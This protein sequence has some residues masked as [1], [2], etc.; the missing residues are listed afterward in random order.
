MPLQIAALCH[1]HIIGPT[2]TQSS[3]LAPE[4]YG[5]K[6]SNNTISL[7]TLFHNQFKYGVVWQAPHLD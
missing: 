3:F 4:M 7:I 5:H 2:K 6:L 1:T